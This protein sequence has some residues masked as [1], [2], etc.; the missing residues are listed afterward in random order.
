MGLSE[1][2][3]REIDT[4]ASLRHLV[5]RRL[6]PDRSAGGLGANLVPATGT[7][8]VPMDP[9]LR[10]RALESPPSRRSVRYKR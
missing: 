9:G 4:T 3:E 6:A 7:Y 2:I 5:L 1:A 10:L 8:Y